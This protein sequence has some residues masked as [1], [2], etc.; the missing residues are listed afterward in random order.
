MPSVVEPILARLKADASV[1]ALIAG[2]IFPGMAPQ[3]TDLPYITF[4][5]IADAPLNHMGPGQL[6]DRH[7]TMQ[8]DCWAASYDVAYRTRSAVNNSLA[9]HREE[10]ANPP[11]DSVLQLAERELPESPQDGSDVTTHR[12][13][14]DMSI[15]YRET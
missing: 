10:S 2:R 11:I 4:T 5:I 15:W 6:P 13:S 14:Q 8:I 1:T 12:I 3:G 9:G 7:A